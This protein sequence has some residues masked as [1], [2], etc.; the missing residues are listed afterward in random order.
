MSA[1][2]FFRLRDGKATPFTPTSELNY[3]GTVGWEKDLQVICEKNLETLFGVKFLE[4]ECSVIGG[5][6]DTLGLD[7]NHRPTIIEYKK[8]DDKFLIN[9]TAYYAKCLNKFLRG[10]FEHK[11]ML[12]WGEEIAER[13]QWSKGPRLICVAA[14]FTEEDIA[15]Q[16]LIEPLELVQYCLS[17]NHQILK[18][19]R[20]V[21][22]A[23]P[24]G[25]LGWTLED[26]WRDYRYWQKYIKGLGKKEE[27]SE[28]FRQQVYEAPH[29]SFTRPTKNGK[30]V[31]FAVLEI[32]DYPV[33]I[34]ARKD[35]DQFYR[36][37]K[38]AW[39]DPVYTNAA[40]EL[41]ERIKKQ[42]RDAYEAAYESEGSYEGS[43]HE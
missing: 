24:Y 16:E 4:T 37:N 19:E 22:K 26:H 12:K 10:E 1:Q 36:H 41:L 13:V 34:W 5:R 27:V 3:P 2:K 43:P 29:Q 25:L 42:L 15:L 23:I 17:D 21:T 40:P 32:K 33:T 35:F 30:Q 28:K 11:A 38:S 20:G 31:G 39:H 18:L 9:Q 14:A 8:G 6:M 7:E